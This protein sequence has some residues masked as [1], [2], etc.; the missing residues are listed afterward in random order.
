MEKIIKQKKF[1]KGLR[2]IDFHGENPICDWI[3]EKVIPYLSDDEG[4]LRHDI[5]IEI[6]KEVPLTNSKANKK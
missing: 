2:D 6:I 3:N 4:S 5:R 1:K